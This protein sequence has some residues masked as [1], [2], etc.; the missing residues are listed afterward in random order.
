MKRERKARVKK[1]LVAGSA[2]V[3]VVIHVDHLPKRGEDINV[4]GQDMSLG[5]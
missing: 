2:V 3:D 5:G 1:V 4:Y